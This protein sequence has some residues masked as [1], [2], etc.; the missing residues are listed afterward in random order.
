LH[1]DEPVPSVFLLQMERLGELPRR[2]R[3]RAEV[4]HLARAHQRVQRLQGLLAGAD[5]IDVG[6]VEEVDPRLD[7]GGEMFARL[8]HRQ[9]PIAPLLVAVTHASEADARDGDSGLAQFRVLHDFSELPFWISELATPK[10]RRSRSL[11]KAEVKSGSGLV[12]SGGIRNLTPN[13][14]PRGKGN[15]NVG[16]NAGKG[17]RRTVAAVAVNKFACT[18]ANRT[19]SISTAIRPRCYFIASAGILG[20]S[21][22]RWPIG[23]AEISRS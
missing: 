22:S 16:P 13:P 4:A 7:R 5:R 10:L 8:V 11:V 20:C 23:Q 21:Q 2:H 1:R 18:C 17:N 3:A 6:G 14:F 12:C 19:A 15:R 9:H